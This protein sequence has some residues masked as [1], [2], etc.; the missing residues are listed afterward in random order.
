[1]PALRRLARGKGSGVWSRL[2]GFGP[3]E[4][5]RRERQPEPEKHRN[6]GL[7]LLLPEGRKS[8][9]LRGLLRAVAGPVRGFAWGIFRRHRRGRVGERSLSNRAIMTI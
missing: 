8:D 9:A 6:Q 7:W 2:G 3:R 5:V 4:G 1:M